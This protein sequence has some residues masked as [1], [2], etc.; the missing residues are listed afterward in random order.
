MKDQPVG[1]GLFLAGSG[2]LL[3]AG[4]RRELRG[5][6]RD[7]EFFLCRDDS[8]TAFGG[9]RGRLCKDADRFYEEK[10]PPDR[11]PRAMV[12]VATVD[13]KGAV[14][15]T[16]CGPDRS[17]DGNRDLHLRHAI[18]RPRGGR[19][20]REGLEPGSSS[21]RRRNKLTWGS[22]IDGLETERPV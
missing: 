3:A 13:K 5:C 12:T 2:I 19:H 1:K 4:D 18:P 10:A 22:L 17:R 9:H 8:D 21:P 15:H 6:A 14:M 11:I 16:S 20:V 7:S